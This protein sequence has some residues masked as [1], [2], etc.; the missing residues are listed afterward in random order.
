MRFRPTS[1]TTLRTSPASR[2]SL[3]KPITTRFRRNSNWGGV[4]QDV[5]AKYGLYTAFDDWKNGVAATFFYELMDERAD[6]ER[7]HNFGLFQADGSPKA[8]AT[9]LHSL[10]TILSDVGQGAGSFNPSPLGVSFAGLPGT[11]SNLVLQKSNG[12]YDVVVWDEQELWDSGNHVQLAASSSDVTV[13]LG[14][15]FASV[16]VF[17][18]LKGTSPIASY[19]NVSKVLLHLADDPLILQLS[20]PAASLVLTGT[21]KADNL[22][23]GVGNDTLDGGSGNDTLTGGAGD[24]VLTGGAGADRFVFGADFGQDI[25]KDFQAK[26]GSH[27]VLAF[28]GAVFATSA[29]VLAHTDD[30]GQG[31]FAR[32]TDAAGNTITLLNVHK[33][34]LAA[35]DFSFA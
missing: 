18:P 35:L 27:D 4:N 5:Q 11:A 30:G 16:D 23:G 32:I 2:P 33:A 8:F 28:A 12:T 19:Q 26:S 6:L 31:G 7:E 21:S 17:D 10:T 24:D 13:S 34:D 1:G 25:I 20:G 22:V 15:T 14:S 3:P 29:D 9:A